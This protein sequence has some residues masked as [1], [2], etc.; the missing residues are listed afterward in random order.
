MEARQAGS[1]KKDL[2]TDAD[3]LT[4][5]VCHEERKNRRSEAS[6]VKET[7]TQ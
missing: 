5:E 6:A 3:I 1:L 2:E 7:M 4:D